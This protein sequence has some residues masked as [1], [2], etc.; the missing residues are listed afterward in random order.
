MSRHGLLVDPLAICRR[1]LAERRCHAAAWQRQ[2]DRLSHARLATFAAGAVVAGA[3][4][5]GGWL[6]PWW[7]AVPAGAFAGLVVW[8]DRVLLTEA[9]AARAV[10]W[11]EHGIARLEDR[12]PGLGPGGDRFA[13]PEH[14][15][16]QDLDLFGDGSLFQLLCTART[17]AGEETLAAWLKT[18]AGP[19]EVA[20]RQAAVRELQPR[21]ALREELNTAAAEMRTSVRPARLA[22]WATGAG[23]LPGVWPR[24]AAI[25]F[26][27]LISASLLAWLGG[28][29]PLGAAV[30]ALLAAAVF[31]HRFHA[32]TTR[33]MHGA[34]EPSRELLVLGEVCRVLRRESYRT[35]R[36][37]ALHAAL[38]APDGEAYAAARQLCRV[39]ERHD[40]QHNIFF[41]PL[42]AVLFWDLHCAFAVEA[43][44]R[45]HGDRVAR[46]LRDT[47][48]FEA[49]AALATYG[50]EHP[51]DP[52]P[53]IAGD[54]GPPVYEAERLSHPLL[55][56]AAA[57]PNDVAL[58]TAPR[59]LIVSGSNMSG[60]TTLLRSV[61]INAVLALAGAPVRAARLR[62]SPLTPGAT[63]RIEDS[64]QAGRSRFYA[65][66]LRLGQ[67]LAAARAGPTL[68]LFDELFHG[69]NSHDRRDGARGLLGSLLELPTLG[70]VTTHDLALAEIADG[71]AP[72]TRN[73]HFDDDVVAGDLR[74]DYRLK[75]GPVTRSN[76]LAIMRAV[77]LD[78]PEADDAPE[79]PRADAAAS[80]S[81]DDPAR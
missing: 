60:K 52:Y 28:V 24:F 53:E 23:Q 25:G 74:F 14:L 33:I 46:W 27:G 79:P 39:V 48:E 57:V 17:Q 65:E 9:R 55:P 36:L 68:F 5:F 73:V 18:P 26:T 7:L 67:I 32:R 50:W 54:A 62:L 12:W 19:T 72:R 29:L 34:D 69:T 22:A 47:G 3:A 40:W 77:G 42:A 63:L 4:L 71:L 45:R 70:L 6:S 15:Y 16:A 78:V 1:L 2:A 56:A 51:A 64:L 37:R 43:W 41:L 21:V 66:V 75:P 80:S 13:D 20:E 11:Y 61:G 44:R 81:E 30:A 8:H 76:A 35:A 31:K 59:V 49:L 58:G 10:A 38:A